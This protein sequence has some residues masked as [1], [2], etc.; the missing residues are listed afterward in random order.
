MALAGRKRLLAWLVCSVIAR[1][2][3]ETGG[4]RV[5]IRW[6]GEVAGRHESQSGDDRLAPLRDDPLTEDL[7]RRLSRSGAA[8]GSGSGPVRFSACQWTQPPPN[9]IGQLLP[10]R[11]SF[12]NAFDAFRQALSACCRAALGIW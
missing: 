11:L 9:R 12:L 2:S 10:V 1:S 6:W 8:R 7:I 5:V 4:L 3:D